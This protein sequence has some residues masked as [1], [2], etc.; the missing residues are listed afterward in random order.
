MK[1]LIVTGAIFGLLTMLITSC[2]SDNEIEFKRYYSTGAVLYQS[3][4]QNCHGDNGEGLSALIPPLTDSAY[5]KKN[6]HQLSCYV[7]NGLNEPV[8][9]NG[10]VYQDKMPP[11]GLGPIE[12]ARVLTYVGNSFGNKLGL[13][14]FEQVT[15]DLKACK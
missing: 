3:H 12:L 5:L 4:C 7:F 14:R 15:E 10:K 9:I 2:L 13:V 8:K 11:S 6:I 1:K